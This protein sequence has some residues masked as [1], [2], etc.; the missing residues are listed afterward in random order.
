MILYTVV[1]PEEIF[2]E[3][4]ERTFVTARYQGVS[5][6]VEPVG[7]GRARLERVLSTDPEDYLRSDLQ[8]GAI[9]RFA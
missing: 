9:L 1:P 4:E 5:V 2:P 3:E 7:D 8:P 6:V